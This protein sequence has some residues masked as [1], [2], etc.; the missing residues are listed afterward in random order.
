MIKVALCFIISYNHILHKEQIWIDWINENKDI[1]NVY[2][3]YTDYNKIKSNWI[4]SH[5]IPP[6]IT[7]PATYYNVV[8]AYMAV[9]SFA[10]S[11][12]VNNQWFCMLTESCVPIIPPS[13]FREMFLNNYNKTIMKHIPANWNVQ[14]QKRANVRLLPKNYWLKNEPWF[15]LSREHVKK[16]MLFMFL[17]TN[18]YKTINAGGLAN[19][20]IFAI[21]LNSF[22]ILYDESQ[23]I[24]KVSTITDWT[25]MSSPT[26]PYLFTDATQENITIINDLLKEN[27]YAMFLRKV[28]SQFPNNALMQFL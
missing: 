26:S 15:T 2:F 7:H 28:H 10:Y 3:H 19:E 1:I 20:S 18:I 13:K 11:H 16:C 5:T 8:P 6:N 9:Q 27:K 24:N 14:L 21:M 23:I 4:K 12:D 22:N 25:R 17:N